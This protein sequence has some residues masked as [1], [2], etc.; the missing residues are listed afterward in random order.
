MQ[1]AVLLNSA[2]TAFVILVY[3]IAAWSG[4]MTL[5]ALR[6]RPHLRL[7]HVFGI[8]WNYLA[9]GCGLR[10][11]DRPADGKGWAVVYVA[12]NL[13]TLGCIV[14][15]AK[16]VDYLIEGTARDMG[17]SWSLP[18]TAAHLFA[19]AA[20]FLFHIAVHATAKNTPELLDK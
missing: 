2:G 4:F 8:V 15:A 19:S 14:F 3:A 16:N 10:S 9:S 1:I 12:V 18:W 11:F 20:T 13:S 17:M 6:T 7:R 5:L